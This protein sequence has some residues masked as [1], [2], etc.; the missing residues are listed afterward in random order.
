MKHSKDIGAHAK[1]FGLVDAPPSTRKDLA[2]LI[3]PSCEV[4][5][6]LVHGRLIYAAI[7]G[8]GEATGSSWV[9][10][11]VSRS[12]ILAFQQ[13]QQQGY[14]WPQVLQYLQTI[15]L[16]KLIFLQEQ[17]FCLFPLLAGTVQSTSF[18]VWK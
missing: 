10:G 14:Q 1:K 15:L 6:S 17:V 13:A 12:F 2:A 4:A 16:K 3:R 18:H 11:V 9:L 7:A 5:A 8:E